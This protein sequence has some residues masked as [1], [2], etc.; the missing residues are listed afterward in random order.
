M[1]PRDP[2]VLLL[3]EPTWEL[4]PL[5]TY[6]IISILSNHAKKYNRIVVLTM[7]KPRRWEIIILKKMRT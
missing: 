6:F 1:M 7:E 3:E 4:D 5:N 2:V